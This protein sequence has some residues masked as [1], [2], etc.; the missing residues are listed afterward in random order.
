MKSCRSPRAA[1]LQGGQPPSVVRRF[2]DRHSFWGGILPDRAAASSLGAIQPPPARTHDVDRPMMFENEALHTND[3]SWTN[4]Q[5]HRKGI[6]PPV[7]CGQDADRTPGENEPKL[8]VP[9][10]VRHGTIAGKPPSTEN[11][12]KLRVPTVVIWI[13]NEICTQPRAAVL[14]EGRPEFN[15]DPY[16][17]RKN[18][19]K[20]PAQ[21]EPKLCVPT[22]V[23]H[24][25]I[26]GNPQRR[27]RTQISCSH[28]HRADQSACLKITRCGHTGRPA[29]GRRVFVHT[30]GSPAFPRVRL[31]PCK[32]R[33]RGRP[34]TVQDAGPETRNRGG[35]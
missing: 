34:C 16:K 19:R 26:A 24:G 23:R 11:K 8:C 3:G 35:G 21:N 17:T 1:D 5:E 25:T 6:A 28:S 15:S 2:P 9:T 31:A 7:G 22:V 20:P 10:V 27:K 33:A 14:R 13:R 30:E 12:P 29:R 4:P 18:S 32:T